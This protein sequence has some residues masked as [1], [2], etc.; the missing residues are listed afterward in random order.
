MRSCSWG[1]NLFQFKE[2]WTG[3]GTFR[4]EAM[5]QVSGFDNGASLSIAVG[6]GQGVPCN[7]G[8]TRTHGQSFQLPKG[9]WVELRAVVGAYQDIE[10][11]MGSESLGRWTHDACSTPVGPVHNGPTAWIF[12]TGNYGDNRGP[13][14]IDDV[15]K[16]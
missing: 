13:V 6:T 12:G 15:G 8:G 4:Q 14:Y 16:R 2:E 11:F 10:F 9:Q 5:W 3:D 7:N 1:V